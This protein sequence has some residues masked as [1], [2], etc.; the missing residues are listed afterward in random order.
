VRLPL[1]GEKQNEPLP[2]VTFIG[3]FHVRFNMI[4]QKQILNLFDYK[5]G[6][7]YYKNTISKQYCDIPVGYKIGNGYWQVNLNGEKLYLHRLVFLMHYGFLPKYVD[8]I[9]RNPLNNKI[10]NLRAAT[11]S[12]NMMNSIVR[13]NNLCGIKGVFY[14]EIRKK[15]VSKISIQGKSYW[16][17]SF[18]T[19][20]DAGE[21]YKRKAKELHKDFYVEN[22]SVPG[23]DICVKECLD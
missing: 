23:V 13:K 2:A 19:K 14:S 6:Y 9:D 1:A 8:H 16:L 12:Q 18:A 10:E 15:W 21:A 22:S 4:T 3:S 17:G 11:Q 5:D 20:E 7:L